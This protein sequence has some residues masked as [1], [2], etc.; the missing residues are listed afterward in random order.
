MLWGNANATDEEIYE[1]LDIAQAREFVDGKP[2]GIETMIEQGGKN[3]S[4]GQKQRLTIAR[5][6]IRRPEILILDDSSSALDFATDAKLRKA[7]KNISDT[8]KTTVII[9]SQRASAIMHADNIIV[10]DDGE[11]SGMGAHNELM[12]TNEVYREIYHSQNAMR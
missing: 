12:E 9:V 6:V 7:L 11:I 8:G 2:E 5:A 3:L 4:G 10:L 1:A